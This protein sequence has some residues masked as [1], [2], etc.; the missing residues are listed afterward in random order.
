MTVPEVKN[1]A[2]IN[3]G[4]EIGRYPGTATVTFLTPVNTLKKTGLWTMAREQY[5][6]E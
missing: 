3:G 2:T 5:G 4:L 6:T 1:R